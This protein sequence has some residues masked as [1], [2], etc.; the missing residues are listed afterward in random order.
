M[1]GKEHQK[2]KKRDEINRCLKEKG[3]QIPRERVHG[4]K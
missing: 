2:K 3:N 1:E 4:M